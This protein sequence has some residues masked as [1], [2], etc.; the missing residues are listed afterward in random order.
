MFPWSSIQCEQR[1][2]RKNPLQPQ[3][4][5]Y[6]TKESRGHLFST[7]TGPSENGRKCCS[8]RWNHLKASVV[9]VQS[10]FFFKLIM[11]GFQILYPFFVQVN[12]HLGLSPGHYTKKLAKLRDST[13]LRQRAVATTIKIQTEKISKEIKNITF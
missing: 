3:G 6:P 12:R 1:N 7:G 9:L 10:N 5:C 11:I 13:R 8:S 4:K 2:E